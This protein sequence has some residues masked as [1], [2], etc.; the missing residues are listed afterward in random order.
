MTGGVEYEAMGKLTAS[1]LNATLAQHAHAEY[2][3]AHL[4][5]LNRLCKH[6]PAG[7]AAL[8]LHSDLFASGIDKVLLVSLAPSV[9]DLLC[10]VD[11]SSR[12]FESVLP[13]IILRFT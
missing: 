8:E 11:T 1:V 10:S 6:V 7:E 2:C 5:L 13:P 12:L 9:S 4:R 3:S